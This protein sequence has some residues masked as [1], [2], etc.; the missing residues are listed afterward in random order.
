MRQ[1]YIYFPTDYSA[2]Q[3]ETNFE[4]KRDAMCLKLERIKKQDAMRLET[5]HIPHIRQELS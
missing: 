1:F 2:A 3:R 4:K 5:T